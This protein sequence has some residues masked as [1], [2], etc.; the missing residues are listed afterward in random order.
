MAE[1]WI[2]LHRKLLEWEWYHKSEMVHLFIHM[3]FKANHKPAKWQGTQVNRGQFVTGR[4]V[5]AK[6]TG[7]SEQR[8]RTILGRLKSTN[9]I[10]I[11]S[12]S[13]FSVITIRNY[14]AYNTKEIQCNQQSN[15]RSHQQSTSNQPAINHK[16]ECKELKNE[17]NTTGTV[18]IP[19]KL[20][21]PE[22]LKAWEDWVQYR[23]D[24]RHKMTQITKQMQLK[25]LSQFS[26]EK[27]IG[28]IEKSIEKGWQ[29]LFPERSENG[30][31]NGVNKQHS[32]EQQ[33][34][35]FGE[36]LAV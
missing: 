18:E 24:T 25:K 20:K 17:K 13:R 26:P 16:Q 11:K 35:E 28:V 7:I 6:E 2:K 33:E 5:L 22:F 32:F 27:A 30:K 31:P 14:N 8:I 12:T 36:T 34:S 1:G 29:G 23:K 3:I 15:P 9:E 4:K 21:T 10:T 19:K